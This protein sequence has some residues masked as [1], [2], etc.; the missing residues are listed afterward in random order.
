MSLGAA[1][2]IGEVHVRVD[3]AGNDKAAGCVDNEIG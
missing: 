3:K 2:G 1:K